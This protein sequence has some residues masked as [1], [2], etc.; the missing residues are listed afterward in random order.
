[1][2]GDFR[3]RRYAVRFRPP[4]FI[5]EYSDD[6]GKT[7]TR[8]VRSRAPS[9]P[10]VPE[11]TRRSVCARIAFPG[12]LPPSSSHPRRSHPP[13]QVSVSVPEHAPDADAIAREV[14]RAFPRRLDRSLVRHP[15]IVRLA[16]R[17]VDAVSAGAGEKTTPEFA[18]DLDLNLVSPEKLVEA[19]AA[20]DEGFERNRKA[21]GDE[22]FEYDVRR[23]FAPTRKSEWDDA[24]D[25]ASDDD[26]D[27]L[28]P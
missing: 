27:D 14:T 19:K 2:G 16:R 3:P 9:S 10:A 17:L 18:E 23:D 6:A 25:D 15:Q 24:S 13:P 12:P 20:M 11:P 26:V 5:L 21:I 22:G 28:L 1:M 4:R 7:R 8:S